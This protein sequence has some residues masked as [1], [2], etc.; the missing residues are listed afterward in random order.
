MVYVHD[1]TDDAL[2]SCFARYVVAGGS[3]GVLVLFLFVF[4][5]IL[6]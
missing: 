1:S 2:G 3:V 6:Q 5:W 4:L